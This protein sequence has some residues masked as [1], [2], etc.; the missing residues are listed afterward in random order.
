MSEDRATQLDISRTLEAAKAA[1]RT[2]GNYLSLKLGTAKVEHQKSPNDDLLDTDLEAEQL[3]LNMLHEQTPHVGAL[4]E[5]AGY[6][7]QPGLCWII[8]P[9]D[10][11]ANFQRGNPVFGVSIA[12]VHNQSS[13]GGVIY[14]PIKDEMFVAIAGQG[15]YLNNN[16]ITVSHITAINEATAHAGDFTKE[17]DAKLSN[18]RLKALLK[19]GGKTKRLRMLGS[20]VTDLAYVACGRADVLINHA[21]DIWDIAAGTLLVQEAGGQVTSKH[22]ENGDLLYIF[23]NKLLHQTVE[24]LLFEQELS[25]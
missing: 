10:G 25:S 16:P 8:D 12:L 18:K 21:P 1:A 23:S 24:G 20:A 2:A 14:L 6:Q 9:L 11:S 4:S 5:E 17:G 3:I 19:L 7:G 15:A 13:L 22:D